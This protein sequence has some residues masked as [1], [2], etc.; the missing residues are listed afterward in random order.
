MI[1]IHGLSLTEI[2]SPLALS[3]LLCFPNQEGATFDC[4]IP[5]IVADMWYNNGEE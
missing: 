1:L 5:Y 3:I 2:L 4:S